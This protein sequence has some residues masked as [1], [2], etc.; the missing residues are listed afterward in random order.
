[1][2]EAYLEQGLIVKDA[3]KLRIH[4]AK[5]RSCLKTKN[6]YLDNQCHTIKI[7][8]NPVKIE[9][10]NKFS[11]ATYFCVGHDKRSTD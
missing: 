3:K 10:K 7:Y 5:N 6:P 2:H 1:M 4:Y 9:L 11:K 8:E